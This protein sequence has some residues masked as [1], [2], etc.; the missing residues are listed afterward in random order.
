MFMWKVTAESETEEASIMAE[1]GFRMVAAEEVIMEDS[2]ENISK[3]E[4]TKKR[5]RRSRRRF[6][7][8][9]NNSL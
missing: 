2:K 7:T 1:D 5:P 9:I 6:G 8:S 3:V 4:S